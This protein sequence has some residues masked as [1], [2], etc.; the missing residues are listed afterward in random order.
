[1]DDRR[2]QPIGLVEF[3]ISGFIFIAAGIRSGDAMA[4][5]GSVLWVAACVVW[6]VP[7][8]WSGKG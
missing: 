5:I 7:L 8:V 6:A 3:I 4:V 1:M 2:N